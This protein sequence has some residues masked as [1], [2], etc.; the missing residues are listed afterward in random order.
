MY[1]VWLALNIVWEIALGAWPVLLAAL[2]LWAVLLLTA[3][4]RPGTRWRGA[5]PWAVGAG[6]LAAAGAIGTVPAWSL[7][8][9][10]EMGYWVD[11][12]NLLAVAAGFG[13]VAAA[14]A[15]PLAAM[16]LGGD[17]AR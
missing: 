12:A 11:W 16:R 7:S 4:R 5:L 8:S 14:V 17:T 13:A 6:V 10:S 9:L 15:W 2:L 3:W 1:E